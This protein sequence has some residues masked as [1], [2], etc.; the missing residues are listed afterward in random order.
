M[1]SPSGA[2]SDLP[3]ARQVRKMASKKRA[4]TFQPAAAA[5]PAKVGKGNVHLLPGFGTPMTAGAGLSFP[6]PGLPATARGGPASSVPPARASQTPQSE[7]RHW[8]GMPPTAGRGMGMG[9]GMGGPA[10]APSVSTGQVLNGH[11][12]VLARCVTAHCCVC[13]VCIMCVC[14]AY[15]VC[16]CAVWGPHHERNHPSPTPTPTHP[17]PPPSTWLLEPASALAR[18]LHCPRAWTPT[19]PAAA[20][21]GCCRLRTGVVRRW[22]AAWATWALR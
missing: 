14:C 7:S 2:P 5:T 20:S 18:W 19:Y 13:A 16:V 1:S 3:P 17:P 9:M 12:P 4:A 8:S 22:P 21:R 11:L 10:A 6:L 15:S